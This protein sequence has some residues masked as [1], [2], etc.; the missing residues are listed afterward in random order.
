MG[1]GVDAGGGG[2][3]HITYVWC[4]KILLMH[5]SLGIHPCDLWAYSRTSLSTTMRPRASIR[6]FEVL[7][8]SSTH[9]TFKFWWLHH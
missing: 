5:G 7:Y 9:P 1:G 4:S 8:M 2:V 3:G 6:N